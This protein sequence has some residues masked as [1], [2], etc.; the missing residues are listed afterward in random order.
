VHTGERPYGCEEPG[1]VYAATQSSTL[2]AHMR[3]HTGERPYA[4]EQPGCGYAAAA[5]GTLAEH[6]RRMHAPPPAAKRARSPP[7]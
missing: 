3:T 1:C 4:C 6:V 7:A 2:T 5:G